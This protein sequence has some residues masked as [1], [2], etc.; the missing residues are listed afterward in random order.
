MVNSAMALLIL[1]YLNV[2]VPLPEPGRYLW[3][4]PSCQEY[5]AS[6]SAVAPPAAYSRARTRGTAKAWK[7]L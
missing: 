3:L 6:G 4:V 7:Q 1:I 5:L 2:T